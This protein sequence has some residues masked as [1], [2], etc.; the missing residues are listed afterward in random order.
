LF[1]PW[2][3]LG[4]WQQWAFSHVL[5]RASANRVLQRD[6]LGLMKTPMKIAVFSTRSY[7]RNFLTEAAVKNP[8]FHGAHTFS[9]HN[10]H[11]RPETLP[12]MKGCDSICAFV[13]DQLDGAILANLQQGG[14]R[15]VA[16]RCA[17]YNNVDLITAKELGITVV[18]VP[19]YSPEAVAEHTVAL[20]L[21]LNRKI[22][23][24]YR[25]VRDGNFSLEGLVGFNLHGKTVGLIGTGRIGLAV[26]QILG[27]GFGCQLLGC[28]PKPNPDCES[29][30]LRYTELPELLS[31][32]DVVSLHAPLV[33]ATSH[34][35]NE[36]SI[37]LMKDGVMLV[38]TSRG[39]LVDTP[40]VIE[41]VKTGKIGYLGLDV[42]EEETEL[43]FDD[44]SLQII[45]DDVFARL[46]TFPNVVIT[47]H[48]A[49][50]TNEALQHIAQTTVEN[51]VEFATTGI[52]R[53]QVRT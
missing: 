38:N 28:D 17:G 42:Y 37:S 23:R 26:A 39:G 51:I 18:R 34:L 5:V 8:S 29:L 2:K 1:Q 11:L 33:P 4:N 12:L 40:A 7:D 30:G 14:T 3:L 15:L 46:L 49:F 52:C 25:R 13:N 32:S 20:I 41:A 21:A 16:L 27:P 6:K 48:Q 45:S 53:N 44:F 35:I 43:F 47:G 10:V 36:Q 22:Y 9:Y 50:L 24:A 19:A 31:N